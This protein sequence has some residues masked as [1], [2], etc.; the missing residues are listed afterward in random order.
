MPPAAPLHHYHHL[1]RMPC[2]QL[3]STLQVVE[4]SEASETLLYEF[5]S[6]EL[7]SSG[8]VTA[9]SHRPQTQTKPNVLPARCVSAPGA[10]CGL[11]LGSFS[12]AGSPA[13]NGQSNIPSCSRLPGSPAEQ[14]TSTC[15]PQPSRLAL[16]GSSPSCLPKFTASK[17]AERSL[18]SLESFLAS[19]L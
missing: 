3:A 2:K 17:A 10:V 13:E 1:I 15:W 7:C 18:S 5:A 9:S 19:K 8:S 12:W 11:L 6:K 4:V 14:Q 16:C